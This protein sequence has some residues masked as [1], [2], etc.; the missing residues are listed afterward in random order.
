MNEQVKTIMKN[1]EIIYIDLDGVIVDIEK[2]IN[3]TFSKDYISEHGIGNIVDMHP[4]VF[5][6]S[7]PIEGAIKSFHELSKKYEVYI[8]STAPWNNP[9]AWTAKRIWVEKHLGEVA[10]KRLILTHNKGLLR[11]DYLIDDRIKYIG[12]FEGAGGETVHH[13]EKTVS[14]TIGFLES[15][16]T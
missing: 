14:K 2:Y 12:Q 15:L 6:D 10:Y 3:R 5:Y 4:K 8:L 16:M 11:G 1:K 7:E 9:E 13:S